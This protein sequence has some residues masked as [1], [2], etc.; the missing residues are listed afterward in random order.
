MQPIVQEFN[1]VKN[2][3]KS[4]LKAMW[5]GRTLN[6]DSFPDWR[7][8]LM[9]TLLWI[10]WRLCLPFEILL[11]GRVSQLF[12]FRFS[13]TWSSLSEVQTFFL[14]TASCFWEIQSNLGSLWLLKDNCVHL[15]F[16]HLSKSRDRYHILFIFVSISFC[17]KKMFWSWALLSCVWIA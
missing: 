11:V 3:P 2:I 12:S 1:F 4:S 15:I 5:K 16:V 13:L 6:T 14:R 9:F 10:W 17:G 7:L 8:R